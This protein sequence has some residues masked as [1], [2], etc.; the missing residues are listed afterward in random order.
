MWTRAVSDLRKSY[1]GKYNYF[2]QMV[3]ECLPCFNWV[4]LVCFFS[5][6]FFTFVK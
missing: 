1:H 5:L 3:S 2:L 6:P 4:A